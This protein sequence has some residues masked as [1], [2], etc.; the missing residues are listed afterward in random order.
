MSSAT[1]WREAELRANK[2]ATETPLSGLLKHNS[3][4]RRGEMVA[5]ANFSR[6]AL[7]AVDWDDRQ[8]VLEHDY[9]MIF[10]DESVGYLSA[11]VEDLGEGSGRIVVCDDTWETLSYEP[12]AFDY[13]LDEMKAGGSGMK[14]IVADAGPYAAAVRK[15]AAANGTDVTAVKDRILALRE[16]A[17]SLV[18]QAASLNRNPTDVQRQSFAV[19]YARLQTERAELLHELDLVSDSISLAAAAL[20]DL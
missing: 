12:G 10:I 8:C 7:A 1:R 20:A 3:A 9:W 15:E 4:S 17:N 2:A 18:V 13:F 6:A 14:F 16:K 19:R 5:A 11:Y